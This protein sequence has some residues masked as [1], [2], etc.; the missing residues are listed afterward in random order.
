ML[1]A[2]VKFWPNEIGVMVV[3]IRSKGLIFG[4]TDS[5]DRRKGDSVKLA[6]E[7]FL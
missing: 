1:E 3:L 2:Q 7:S 4:I 6:F 5:K